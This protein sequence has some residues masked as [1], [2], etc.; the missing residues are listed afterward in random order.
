M[1]VDG[2][3]TDK[4]PYVFVKAPE[5]LLD[6]EKVFCIGDT[7]VDFEPI[8]DNLGIGEKLCDFGFIIAGHFRWIEIGKGP[9]VSFPFFKNGE[10]AEPRLRPF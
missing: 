2:L 9:S 4:F 6:F 5:L 1:V 8:A 3:T 7:G 10:P